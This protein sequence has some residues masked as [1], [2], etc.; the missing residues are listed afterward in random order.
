MVPTPHSY[1]ELRLA[2]L[3]NENKTFCTE[4]VTLFRYVDD[5]SLIVVVTP[6]P[7]SFRWSRLL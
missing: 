6:R 2:A 4:N 1:P 7:L 3:S 5:V